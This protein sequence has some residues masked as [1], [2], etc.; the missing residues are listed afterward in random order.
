MKKNIILFALFLILLV[1]GFLQA[2][3]N[4][5]YNYNINNIQTD[6]LG[7]PGDIW[8]KDMNTGY[9]SAVKYV[10]STTCYGYIYKTTNGGINWDKTW[11][12]QL[13]SIAP[14]SQVANKLAMSFSN[15]NTNIGYLVKQT[16]RYHYWK[17]TDGGNTFNQKDLTTYFSEFASEPVTCVSANNE[18]III[19]KDKPA[20][21]RY[22]SIVN[23]GY[24]SNFGPNIALEHIEISKQTN[25]IYVGGRNI[26]TGYP[27]LAKSTT[28]GYT[29]SIIPQFD[30]NTAYDN[31]QTIKHISIVNNGTGDI[32]KLS[33]DFWLLDYN[34]STNSVTYLT[35]NW[36]GDNK[37]CFS[38][39]IHGFYLKK[40]A[41]IENDEYSVINNVELYKT[42]N[43]G[44]NWIL[45]YTLNNFSSASYPSRFFTYG[46]CVYLTNFL[47]PQFSFVKRKLG[48]GIA[49]Y[50]DDLST[51]GRIFINNNQVNTPQSI[52]F[53]YS[54]ISL[55]SDSKINEY[56]DNEKI[57]Y[58]WNNNTFNNSINSV[59]LHYDGIITNH[60]KTRHI[61][62]EAI[63]ISNSN[64]TKALRLTNGSTPMVHSSIGG[65]FYSQSSS[66]NVGFDFETVVNGGQ[67]YA[68]LPNSNTADNNKN[69][70][71][72]EIKFFSTGDN[73]GTPAVLTMASVWE[74]RDLNS[75]N[76]DILCALGTTTGG[77]NLWTR[78]GNNLSALDG[79]ITT[80]STPV[81][82]NSKSDIY[83]IF[84]G[85]DN[86]DVTDF[87]MVI[88]HLE[89]TSNGRLVVSVRYKNLPGFD[90]EALRIED[91]ENY[92]TRDYKVIKENVSDYSVTYNPVLIGNFKG[93]YLY[94]TY[95]KNGNIYYQRDLIY[96]NSS[97]NQIIRE[98]VPI[99]EREYCVSDGDLQS[100]RNTPD[101]TLRNGMPTIS[102]QGMNNM[103]R[104]IVYEGTSETEN[105][106]L[107]LP[108]L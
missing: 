81:N 9:V 8:F 24:E 104:E 13:P 30:G 86:T 76:T 19:R 102:Y 67:E 70:S 72:N 16:D 87:L 106:L 108:P 60:F 93:V 1:N 73:G 37:I 35:D 18:L 74:R 17:T 52:I 105:M 97:L 33:C 10:N 51:S 39:I 44:Q 64:Q 78:Y 80:F 14:Q 55:Y 91:I 82:F 23:Y 101:I 47:A 58:K 31:A 103:T 5:F 36:S 43:N 89:P 61:S 68:Q 49:T 20:V 54:T 71:L 7:I 25:I 79:K 66:P 45:D 83:S 15:A 32:L 75:N 3:Q 56:A 46:Q 98:E 62:T 84:C 38:D 12:T 65:I 42:S 90:N 94:F 48:Y 88:P 21:Y 6:Q 40:D 69:P 100:Q 4:L 11:Y 99:G 28:D 41:L 22:N 53:D 29:Y 50:Y 63:A 59:D 57:F 92:E 34:T 107:A 95:K 85:A 2:Q 96:L 27:F 26:N 77:Y